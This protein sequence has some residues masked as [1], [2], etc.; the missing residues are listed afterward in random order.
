MFYPSNGAQRVVAEFR[1]PAR[2]FCVG[3]AD[4]GC[5]PPPQM[6]K[7]GAD[8]G[9]WS[10]RPPEPSYTNPDPLRPLPG[11][12]G[13]LAAAPGGY[14]MHT[15]PPR[16]VAPTPPVPLHAVPGVRGACQGRIRCVGVLLCGRWV[17]GTRV[18]CWWMVTFKTIF[19]PMLYGTPTHTNAA[20]PTPYPTGGLTLEGGVDLAAVPR[21]C[22]TSQLGEPRS[23][24]HPFALQRKCPL[25]PCVPRRRVVGVS[26]PR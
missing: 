22:A 20:P 15:S 10:F 12:L 11:P 25:R 23:V 2:P 19:W 17:G 9:T 13:D 26:G 16:W 21:P 18:W 3:C 4:F 6:Q 7:R 5:A 24:P 8:F 1:W 14:P